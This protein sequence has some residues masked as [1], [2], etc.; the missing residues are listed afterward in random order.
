[1]EV[2][3][4]VKCVPVKLRVLGVVKKEDVGH[5][6]KMTV[7]DVLDVAKAEHPDPAEV[8]IT[9]NGEEA[10]LDTEVN[11]D[12]LIVITPLIDQG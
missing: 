6:E 10:K 8:T 3:K 1:M 7:A 12:D 11:D 5:K 9:V 4:E 2:E